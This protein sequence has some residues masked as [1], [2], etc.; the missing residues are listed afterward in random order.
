M[1]NKGRTEIAERRNW[2]AS[3]KLPLPG[4]KCWRKERRFSR[5]RGQVA[6]GKC[7]LMNE[8]QGQTELLALVRKAH[9]SP[10]VTTF[11][12]PG[13]EPALAC[14]CLTAGYKE[15]PSQ[16]FCSSLWYAG[17]QARSFASPCRP[18]KLL[19]HIFLQ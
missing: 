12:L 13:Q 17:G 9:A 19:K 7:D 15:E 14:Q 18:E 8:F 10:A 5:F 16:H 2:Q 4:Q 1:S 11:I 6:L 3:I